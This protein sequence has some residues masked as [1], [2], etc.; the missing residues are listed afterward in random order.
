MTASQVGTRRVME[1]DPEDGNCWVER[2][3]PLIVYADYEATTSPD[4]VQN[5]ILVCCE[6]EEDDIHVF[7]GDNCTEDFVN[8]LDSLCEDEDG[9]TRKLIA[10]FHNFKGYDGMFVLDYLYNTHRNIEDQ[11]T[12]G[13]K[14][15]SL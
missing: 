3:P 11:V 2:T 1:V 6:S 8:H 14:I 5:P 4:G 13:C 15:L 7:Y 9:D 10:V 12:V